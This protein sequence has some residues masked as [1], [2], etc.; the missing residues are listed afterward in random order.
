MYVGVLLV[1]DVLGLRLV[2]LPKHS[3]KY[4][5]IFIAHLLLSRL[6]QMK[7]QVTSTIL[8]IIIC[9]FYKNVNATTNV[10]RDYWPLIQLALVIVLDTILDLGSVVQGFNLPR[11]LYIVI[12]GKKYWY[13]FLL[14]KRRG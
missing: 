11:H 7:N 5:S 1:A 6:A 2:A 12:R 4:Q 14:C 8:D 9:L 3:S 13:K 10:K